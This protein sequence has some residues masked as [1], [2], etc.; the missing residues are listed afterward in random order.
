MRLRYGKT[1]F[2]S[3]KPKQKSKFCW[4]FLINLITCHLHASW[5][6]WLS[7]GVYG[8]GHEASWTLWPWPWANS[9][10]KLGGFETAENGGSPRSID[11]LLFICITLLEHR[12][13][14]CNII[15]H[16]WKDQCLIQGHE[17]SPVAPRKTSP[18]AAWACICLFWGHLVARS[19]LVIREV[20]R[21]ILSPSNS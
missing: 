9:G 4:V 21:P 19:Y 3:L 10:C 11:P 7:L 17:E 20:T 12:W 5:S 6:L 13:P 1:A 8:H 14:E 15:L 18:D 2:T 16:M